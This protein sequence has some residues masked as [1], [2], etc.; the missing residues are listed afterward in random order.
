MKIFNLDLTGM[1]KS[2]FLAWS[3]VAVLSGALILTGC[4][5]NKPVE[6]P[7]TGGTPIAY[8]E[9][10]GSTLTTGSD[11]IAY[12]AI[13][14]QALV[15]DLQK[16][17]SIKVNPPAQT[18]P[19]GGTASFYVEAFDATGKS[20]GMVRYSD[21]AIKE[22]SGT[23]GATVLGSITPQGFKV[24]VPSN[25]NVA[26]SFSVALKNKQEIQ[27][28]FGVAAVK[29]QAGVINVADSDVLFPRVTTDY[30][31]ATEA[32]VKSQLGGFTIEEYVA[33]YPA[34]VN[35]FNF[36]MVI[37]SPFKKLQVGSIIHISNSATM[38]GKIKTLK[39]KGSNYLI[40]L[41][42]VGISQVI[43][44]SGNYLEMS[45]PDS[46]LI[47][48]Q[49]NSVGLSAQ[50]EES[51]K[52]NQPGAEKTIS[53]LPIKLDLD[54]AEKKAELEVKPEI[55][56]AVNL[57]GYECN[58]EKTLLK[59]GFT[60]GAYFWGEVNGKIAFSAE[61]KN[62]FTPATFSASV[63]YTKDFYKKEAGKFDPDFDLD[64]GLNVNDIDG[65]PGKLSGNV[66]ATPS[67][68]LVVT[69]FIGKLQEKA[70][71]TINWLRSKG[72]TDK[73][74]E[75]FA[76]IVFS[77]SVPL[78]LEAELLTPRTAFDENKGS[79]ASLKPSLTFEVKPEGSAVEIL[80]N[81][82]GLE[83]PSFEATHD[84]PI[85]IEST[86]PELQDIN[87]DDRDGTA[88]INL[89]YDKPSMVT[90]NILGD[91]N[92]S[93]YNSLH[94][95]SL[96]ATSGTAYYDVNE[97]KS[98]GVIKAKVLG[99]GALMWNGKPLINSLPFGTGQEVE[100]C[101]RPILKAEI[102]D[103]LIGQVGDYTDKK[104]L[105]ISNA[106]KPNT[107]LDWEIVFSDNNL[108]FSKLKGTL[109]GGE[110]EKIDMDYRC[111]S[112]KKL[113]AQVEVKSA[114][115]KVSKEVEIECFDREYKIYVGKF[116]AQNDCWSHYA[117]CRNQTYGFDGA[118][119]SKNNLSYLG[120]GDMI[121]PLS[122][123]VVRYWVKAH[124]EFNSMWGKHYFD[125]LRTE[126]IEG[127]PFVKLVNYYIVI[128][129]SWL[130]EAGLQPPLNP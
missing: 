106:G 70:V 91:A 77:V 28:Q 48:N 113:K 63:T 117:D 71:E 60:M 52:V 76:K 30:A 38:F 6:N 95:D 66:A 84:L 102:P 20:L 127:E 68:N 83:L 108:R 46:A 19:N 92:H 44:D 12:D 86:I 26:R 18:L 11:P 5:S 17:V 104:G 37:R 78:K 14:Q 87:V 47:L 10:P 97:C 112:V 1:K 123:T 32:I 82:F 130:K 33:A 111:D 51:C 69:P 73:D 122:D 53:L 125:W 110:T 40:T 58:V 109:K 23:T 120:N 59:K 45:I 90:S 80:K 72:K 7:S 9:T 42:M 15:T 126:T 31:N 103:S 8:D 25:N 96:G 54:F 62:E 41:E 118:L 36:P 79:E 94:K 121:Y 74:F 100:V 105:N 27:G 57:G 101:I 56:A 43:R 98:K 4:G 50:S 34:Q 93:K 128:K 85:K 29:L 21:L 22:I 2:T 99:Y 64:M 3:K 67:L 107:S 81:V 35:Q 16:V 88:N 49:S 119:V 13:G 114:G 55:S 61:M 124:P 116:V 39:Q 89:T 75:E 65:L 24:A 129:S 115:E